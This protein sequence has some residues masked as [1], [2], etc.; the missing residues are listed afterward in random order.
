MHLHWG[1]LPTPPASPSRSTSARP[2]AMGSRSCAGTSSCACMWAFGT[3]TF[4][5]CIALTCAL[6]LL[7]TCISH[8]QGLGFRT[9][10]SH[11]LTTLSSCRL[12][13]NSETKQRRCK[14]LRGKIECNFFKARKKMRNV[15]TSDWR[16]GL[17]VQSAAT[18]ASC[19]YRCAWKWKMHMLQVRNAGHGTCETQVRNA[20]AK[21]PARN[22]SAQCKRAEKREV[23][24]IE[25]RNNTSKSSARC[26]IF[27]IRSA[28]M[29]VHRMDN[30]RP[31]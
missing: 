11:F 30:A 16:T 4:G 12:K 8:L 20:S 15:T 22:A 17:L 5:A 26:S 28:L 25:M 24:K 27:E 18:V 19:N 13:S 2:S 10:F 23:C 21:R 1:H 29:Q 7:G 14:S 3:C 9:S 31:Q 6:H